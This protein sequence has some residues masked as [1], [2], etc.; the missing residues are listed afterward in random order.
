M[1]EAKASYRRLGD[2]AAGYS[3]KKPKTMSGANRTPGSLNVSSDM[4]AALND[5]EEGLPGSSTIA[6][7]GWG[8]SEGHNPALTLQAMIEKS[9]REVEAAEKA[10]AAATTG[11]APRPRPEKRDRAGSDGSQG[12]PGKKGRRDPAPSSPAPSDP[13]AMDTRQEATRNPLRPTNMKELSRPMRLP[14]AVQIDDNEPMGNP[15]EQTLDWSLKVDL[16][17]GAAGQPSIG[18]DFSFDKVD[19]KSKKEKYRNQFAVGWEPGVKIQGEWQIDGLVFY[20]AINPPNPRLENIVFP[21][22]IRQLLEGIKE[23]FR[24]AVT[25]KLVCATFKS[26]A[27]RTTPMNPDWALAL[28]KDRGRVP[29]ANLQSMYRGK[30]KSY[31]VTIWFVPRSIQLERLNNTCLIPLYNAAIDHTPPFHQYTD[32]HGEP[33]IN[34]DLPSIH[35]IGDGMYVRYPKKVDPATREKVEDKTGIPTYHN[36]PKIVRWGSIKAFLTTF[37]VPVVRDLQFQ[38]GIHS[39]LEKDWHRVF[40][41]RMPAYNV[42]GKDL[43]PDVKFK[44]TFRAGIRLKRDPITGLKDTVPPLNSTVKADFFNGNDEEGIDHEAVKDDLWY[45]VVSNYGGRE[46]LEATGTDFCVLLTKP[47]RFPW[48]PVSHKEAKNRPDD[49]LPRVKITVDVNPEPALRDQKGIRKFCDENFEPN[50]LD[51][52]RAAFWSEPSHVPKETDLTR[53]PVHNQSDANRDRYKAILQELKSKRTYNASQEKVLN[54]ASKM[55]S[56]IVTVHGPPGAGKTRTMRDKIIALAKVG[57]KVLCVAS[58][59]VAVDTDA[60]AVWEGLTEEERK[61]YKCLRLETDAA[62]KASR[63]LKRG[64]GQYTGKEGETDQFPEYIGEQEAVDNPKIR[65]SLDKLCAEYNS[66]KEYVE[67]MYRSYT[68]MN[69]AFKASRKY[70]E[71]KQANVQNGMTLDYCIS[72]ILDEDKEKAEQRYQEAL[73]TAPAEEREK[74][75]ADENFTVRAFDDS[76][77]YKFCMANYTENRGKISTREKIELENEVDQMVIRVLKGVTIL[78][79]TASN[80]GGARLEESNAFEPTVIFCDEAGQITVASLC[81]P[82]TTFTKWEGLFLFGDIKQLEPT[83]LSGQFNE[84]IA[85]AKTSPLA[86]LADNGFESILLDTQYRMAPACSKF[87][88]AQFYDDQ[89]L[90]DSDTVQED[91]EVRQTIRALSLE[92]DVK[93]DNGEGSEYFVRN[94]PNGCSRVEVHGTSLVNHA[95]VDAIIN[96]IERLLKTGTVKAGMIKVLTYYQ[97]Q[98]RLLLSKISQ[99]NWPPAIKKAIVVSTVDSFQGREARVVIVDIVAAKDKLRNLGHQQHETPEDDDD[100]DDEDIGGENYIKA[101]MVTGHVRNFNRLNV[102]LTRGRDSTIVVCQAALLVVSHRAGRSKASNPLANLIGDAKGRKCISHDDTEDMHP[103]SVKS[104]KDLSQEKLRQLRVSQRNQD[105]EFIAMS[106]NTW[107]SQ[108][109]QRSALQAEPRQYYRVTGGHTTRHL[110]KPEFQAQADAYDDEQRQLELAKKASEVTEAERLKE[111]EDLQLSIKRS[112]EQSDFPPLPPAK[113]KTQDKKPGD[114]AQGDEEED[115]DFLSPVDEDDDEE[116]P[117]GEGFGGSDA[118]GDDEDR[119]G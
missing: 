5:I 117:V 83:A 106:R 37:G 79:T 35:A 41:Q 67:S 89:G 110:S 115:D 74:L 19:A 23:E 111:Q 65:N 50:L 81:V 68:D 77:R 109:G 69:E 14:C 96:L 1:L 33:I 45:G 66:R 24:P 20:H 75:I 31:Q 88:R 34:S 102:A 90:K 22:K 54:A 86:L 72:E 3:K 103:E 9:Q 93:G 48:R 10:E 99:T 113:D 51:E 64:Y 105:L 7:E 119:F 15:F 80:C 70:Q 4:G 112:M 6:N 85:N 49:A 73:N 118:G 71:M 27:H 63:L 39:K 62:E 100:N 12:I 101:G 30:N 59:N 76:L 82:M 21:K 11:Q 32:S 18:L 52:I 91:N 87:P 53:G 61:T 8:T 13:D 16:D 56:R 94:V 104:R 97:G 40:L 107:N 92:L 114:K 47:R 108:K 29:Y 46:W 44:D 25:S 116:A 78:F 57:H 17:A 60:R 42:D 58:S 43:T 55:K 36:L 26:N 95:N 98:R 38:E 28:G 84:F 2:P